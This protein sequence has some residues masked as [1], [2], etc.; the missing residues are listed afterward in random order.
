MLFNV[1]NTSDDLRG[2]ILV[3]IKMDIVMFSIFV[4]IHVGHYFSYD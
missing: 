1:C 2:M 3:L 4:D